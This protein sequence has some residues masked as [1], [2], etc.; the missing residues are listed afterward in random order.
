MRK[1]ETIEVDIHDLKIDPVA[2]E[3]NN[4]EEMRPY[5]NC[6]VA[7][8]KKEG[9]EEALERIA[10]LKLNERY[11]WR[12]ASALDWAF[13]DCDSE[14]AMLDWQ[15]MPDDD[16]EEISEILRPRL[17]QFALFLRALYGEQELR[18]RFEEAL[19]CACEET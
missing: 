7:A 13:A 18:R 15:L 2:D 14:S 1:K 6:L 4:S 12:V 9:I 17:L 10:A 3:L 5:V 19:A 11:V 16:R 8:M